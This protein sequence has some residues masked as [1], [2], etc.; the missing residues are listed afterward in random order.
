ME[1]RADMCSADLR[2]AASN[3]LLSSFLY[4]LTPKSAHRVCVLRVKEMNTLKY[5]QLQ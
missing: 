1:Y 2:A 3:S 4:F 5:R